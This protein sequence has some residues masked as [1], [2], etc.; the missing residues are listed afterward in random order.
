MISTLAAF[1]QILL[2]GVLITG[3]IGK[4][5]SWRA[6]QRAPVELGL[7][8]PK[9]LWNGLPFLEV[10]VAT[11]IATGVSRLAALAGLILFSS[12]AAALIV[13]YS[14][15]VRGACNCLGELLPTSVGP[16][17]IGRALALA[18]SSGVLLAIGPTDYPVLVVVATSASLAAALALGGLARRSLR[19]AA[20]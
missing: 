10:A 9:I 4:A 14:R 18:A 8:G 7:G 6:W 19:T 13:S 12:F 5:L 17:A 20:D 11:G 15:G 1:L 3:A 16:L 2:A